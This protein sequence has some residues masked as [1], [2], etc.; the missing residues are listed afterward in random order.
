MKTASLVALSLLLALSACELLLT[1]LWANP[2]QGTGATKVV[3]IHTNASHLNQLINR[4]QFNPENPE[5]AFRTDANGYI[6]PG[7]QFEDPE[8]TVAFLGGSTTEMLLVAEDLRLSARVSSLLQAEGL[9][10]NTINAARSG[11]TLHDS[12]NIMF[13]QIQQAQP[14]FVVIMHATNDQG[15]IQLDPQY[16]SRSARPV[17]FNKLMLYSLQK[18]SGVSGLF[19]L[20]RQAYTR[21]DNTHT[22][23]AENNARTLTRDEAKPFAARLNTV[24]AMARAFGITPVLMTQPLAEVDNQYTPNWANLANQKLFNDVIRSIARAT[25]TVVIDLDRTMNDRFVHEK[26]VDYLYDGMHATDKGAK[27][28]A[29]IVSTA[30]LPMMR[31]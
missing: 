29:Q 10:V 12:I 28:Y 6:L 13:N 14:D 31:P 7:N 2:Y 30:L 9:R 25:S 23:Y 19:G 18:L 1:L 8:Y 16:L 15:V 4:A 17:S 5:V 24:V 22:Q 3:E 26:P 20:I 11:N 21:F 27:L